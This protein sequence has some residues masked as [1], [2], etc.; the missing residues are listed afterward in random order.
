MSTTLGVLA[1]R[2]HLSVCFAAG[3][4]LDRHRA[5]T[6]LVGVDTPR[7]FD[8]MT[9]RLSLD[10]ARP[11]GAV[12]PKPGDLV[13]GKY[14]IERT[15]GRGGMGAVF[16]VTHEV[17]GR[18]FAIKWLLAADAEGD[19]AVKRFVREARI[20]GRIQHPHVVDVYDIYQEAPGVF[21]VMELL[22]GQ[23]LASRLASE[24]CLSVQEAC[25]IMLPCAAGVAAAHA[26]GVVHRD[27]KPA[28]IF[29]CRPRA[30]D[31]PHPKVL[32]F[33]ISRLLSTPDLVDTA[34][35]HA[36]TVIGTPYYMAP[37]QLHGE[38]GDHRVD[39][40]ALGVTLYE[41]L[42]GKRPFEAVSYP[43]LVLKIVNGAATPLQ[44]LVPELRPGLSA[45]VARAMNH[46]PEA[47][48]S[49]VE[50]FM[51][52]LEPYAGAE[53]VSRGPARRNAPHVR[54]L[55]AAAGLV[56]VISGLGL[57]VRARG[58]AS[59]E[60]PASRPT[61]ARTAHDPA[62]S[63]PAPAQQPVQ[64]TATPAI[65]PEP[66]A[67]AAAPAASKLEAEPPRDAGKDHVRRR[68]PVRAKTQRK[69]AAAKGLPA[70]DAT[71]PEGT[72]GA[73]EPRPEAARPKP[74]LNLD[75]L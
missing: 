57:Y 46:D 72:L 37:E 9:R 16:A 1:R 43:D 29:L 6:S 12:L 63:A 56:A 42:S 39:V 2:C 64:L 32:D 69:S 20:A 53:P 75:A 67:E 34:E 66:L 62:P 65:S 28:N 58:G 5:V 71:T 24:G 61:A 49:S 3:E 59:T 35:T 45:V 33:G 14:R 38:P 54:G 40:Y 10:L 25:S 21:M 19:E 13:A 73:R 8:D 15:L 48:F 52:A 7:V 70:G 36:G 50:D 74:R 44:A 17:T 68:E 31:Q 60:R 30:G 41:L 22:E 4:G 18:R 23:S 26:A 47:R 11:A 51:R 27:L 55:A